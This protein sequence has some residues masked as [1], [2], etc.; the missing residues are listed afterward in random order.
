MRLTEPTYGRGLSRPTLEA[1]PQR[2]CFRLLVSALACALLVSPAAFAADSTK[3]LLGSW[4][5]KATGPQGGPPTGDIA[6]IM[7]K[8]PAGM[9]GTITVKAPGGAQYSGQVENIALKN[10][11]FSAT[12]TFKLGENPLEVKVSGPLKGKTIMGTFTVLSRGQKMGDGTF[13]ITK[14]SAPPKTR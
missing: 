9:K 6:V 2:P 1:T 14:G 3:I 11:L 10:G 5:G 4:S 12:A 13:T 8:G 7:E